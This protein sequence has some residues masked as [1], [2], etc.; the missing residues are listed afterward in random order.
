MS[1]ILKILERSRSFIQPGLDRMHNAMQE[2]GM[3]SKTL[4]PCVLI[5]GT[6]GKGSTSGMLWRM[7]SL[8]GMR[9]GLYNS[10]HVLSFHERIQCS[11]HFLPLEFLEKELSEL[12]KQLSPQTYDAL[13]F[14]EL[15][16]LLAFF[17]FKRQG[18]EFMVLEV[19]LGGRWDA[20]NVLDPLVSAVVSI[21]FDHQ[22]WLGETLQEIARE[23]LG[24]AR[25]DKALF[26]G[27][28]LYEKELESTLQEALLETSFLLFKAGK[29]F[30]SGV[31]KPLV[32]LFEGR[33]EILK[34]NF[35]LAYAI[36]S[37]LYSKFSFENL[38]VPA[39]ILMEFGSSKGPWPLSFLGRMQKLRV[40]GRSR[41]WEFY[42]DVCHNVA[43]VRECVRTLK[44]LNVHNGKPLTGFVSILRD[45]EIS[46]MIELLHEILNPIM[47]FKIDHE[48]SI[49]REQVT[50]QSSQ[51]TL[52][53]SFEEL[54]KDCA[55]AVSSPVL[56]C[57]S[58]YAVGKVI[59]YFRAYPK[60]FSGQSQLFAYDPRDQHSLSMLS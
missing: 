48:R 27:D 49:S 52:Y 18:C 37:W 44:S 15:T 56:I 28:L 23:K 22:E 42:L 13:S 17:V 51:L 30:P 46:P 2:L 38:K 9:C 10:P 16:T 25:K 20:T 59:D 57:G 32:D 50:S 8:S 47:V 53:E 19:G 40:E 29:D 55:D 26:W 12:K 4:P 36:Y 5:G 3:N 60:T 14:F 6:N 41:T 54:W 1:E 43:S 58:F 35:A 21:D 11:H 45:K 33:A 39:E 34:S 24:I 7:L 31:E